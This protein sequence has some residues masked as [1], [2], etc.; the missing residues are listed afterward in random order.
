MIKTISLSAV[1]LFTINMA[2][3]AAESKPSYID[4]L[5][6]RVSSERTKGI[7]HVKHNI[8]AYIAKLIKVVEKDDTAPTQRDAA[9][10][11]AILRAKDA[12]PALV[13][14]IDYK[15]VICQGSID[16]FCYPF[17]I[18]LAEIGHPAAKYVWNKHVP[19]ADGLKLCLYL[20]VM[21]DVWGTEIC[22]FLID[23]KLSGKLNAKAKSNLKIALV[24][25]SKNADERNTYKA[26]GYY[27]KK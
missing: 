24:Y 4:A 10:L 16:F 7:N 17:A 25:C 19:E 3:F 15:P 9:S 14:R 5:G 11:L 18:A 20:D 2:L 27:K 23:K 22:T 21:S 12:I 1:F 6:S 26:E 13:K 8:S